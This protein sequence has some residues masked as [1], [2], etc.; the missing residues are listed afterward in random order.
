[1]HAAPIGV[2]VTNADGHFVM[3]NHAYCEFYGYQEAEDRS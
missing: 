3:V 2:C 1:M